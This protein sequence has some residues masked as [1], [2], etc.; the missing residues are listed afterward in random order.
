MVDAGEPILLDSSVWVRFLRPR[1]DLDLKTA[2]QAALARGRVATCWIV[3]TELLV[4]VRELAE[5]SLLAETLSGL[6]DI[7]LTERLWADAA[8]LGYDLR[9]AGL[10]IAL[11]DLVIAQCAISSGRTLWHLDA[12]FERIRSATTLATRYWD[13]AT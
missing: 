2:V 9:R 13:A 5:F 12:G 11:P 4:G 10:P 8:R 3:K 7:P 6:P 1:G